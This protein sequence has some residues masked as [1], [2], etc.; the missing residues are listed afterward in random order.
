MEQWNHTA[1]II[2][3]WTYT[4]IPCICDDISYQPNHSTY[5][6]TQPRNYGIMD[7][8]IVELHCPRTVELPWNY[9]A[10][11]YGTTDLHIVE[12]HGPG[13]MVPQTCTLWNYIAP[14]LWN[15]RPAHY[16]TT[17]P[18]NYGT[19]DLYIMELQSPRTVYLPI[20][21]VHVSPVVALCSHNTDLTSHNP[22][23]TSHNITSLYY[24]YYYFYYHFTANT[25]TTIVGRILVKI[26]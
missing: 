23:Q 20:C 19:T 2:E 10:Q 25:T 21:R 5:G 6:T 26:T 13:S 17:W 4:L 8:Y 3:L 1:K 16:G 11:N 12:W 18:R 14:E 15:Y 7:M 22:S 24:F 9:I